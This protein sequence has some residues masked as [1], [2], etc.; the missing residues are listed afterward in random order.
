MM[1]ERQP[2]AIERFIGLPLHTTAGDEIG[3]VGRF[4]TN[5]VSD[6]PEWLVVEQ[7]ILG[8]RTLIVPMAA[9]SLEEDERVVSPYELSLIE[10]QP[11]VE[12]DGD[13]LTIESEDALNEHFGLGARH[14]S[15]GTQVS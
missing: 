11:D 12:I 13:V 3:T 14:P 1:P 9:A 15:G 2:Q 7:G 5:R 4:L 10:A 6:L 8:P